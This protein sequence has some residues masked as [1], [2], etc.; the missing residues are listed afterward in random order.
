MTPNIRRRRRNID[1]ILAGA[2]IRAAFAQERR[3]REAADL[4]RRLR[5]ECDD[6]HRTDGTHDPDVE[7]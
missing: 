4:R 3:K 7:H 1:A 2:A 6:C 5:M